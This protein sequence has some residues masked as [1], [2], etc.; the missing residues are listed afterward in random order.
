MTCLQA[1]RHNFLSRDLTNRLIESACC[2][3]RQADNE[4][5]PLSHQS[6]GGTSLFPHSDSLSVSLAD[7]DGHARRPELMFHSART[8][9]SLL[10]FSK[11]PSTCAASFQSYISEPK[12]AMGSNWRA[13]RLWKCNFIGGNSAKCCQMTI[14]GCHKQRLSV[15][16]YRISS[17][18]VALLLLL[19][20][21]I[22]FFLT[23]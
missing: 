23:G 21:D 22:F 6:A 5:Q 13:V 19:F 2:F 4:N 8:A 11:S 10:T 3:S 17:N 7:R 14:P 20:C 9:D 15:S 1:E 12:A 18:R 16:N